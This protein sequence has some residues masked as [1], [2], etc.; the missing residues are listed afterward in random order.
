MAA[1]AKLV[2]TIVALVH[3]YIAWFEIFAW[4]SRGPKIFSSFPPELFEQTTAMAANQGL[5]NAFLAAGLIWSLCIVDSLWHR[6]V[7][8]CFLLMVC[9]AGIFGAFTVSTKILF[10]QTIPALL[11]IVLLV[12]AAKRQS[13]LT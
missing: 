1:L 2:I 3:C 5:Y 12:W 11:G 8:S 13:R 6:R 9:S 4:T 10:V 7:A